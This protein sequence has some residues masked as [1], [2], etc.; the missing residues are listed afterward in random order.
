MAR[1]SKTRGANNK[2]LAQRAERI[3][4][5]LKK[6]DFKFKKK[7]SNALVERPNC[8]NYGKIAKGLGVR[9]GPNVRLISLQLS[10]RGLSR[11]QG[12]DLDRAFKHINNLYVQGFDV[13]SL[14]AEL[15]GRI[16]STLIQ[17]L[18]F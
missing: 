15:V 17:N 13:E 14:Y 11:V 16:Q 4:R 9:I 3:A 18:P 1:T 2:E 5:S 10:S 12:F 7:H 6:Y 8:E